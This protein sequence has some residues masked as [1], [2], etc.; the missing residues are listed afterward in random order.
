[1]KMRPDTE[2]FLMKEASIPG[3]VKNI[4]DFSKLPVLKKNMMPELHQSNPPFGGFLAVP[5]EKLKRIYVSPG[6]SMIR[7]EEKKITGDCGNACTMQ[8][9]GRVTSS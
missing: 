9:S 8:D 3:A 2:N 5:V 1:M 4:D 6:P 7:K